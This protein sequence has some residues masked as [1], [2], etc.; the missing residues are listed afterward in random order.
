MQHTM[1]PTKPTDTVT[2]PKEEWLTTRTT[3]IEGVTK[4]LPAPKAPKVAGYTSTL[5][6]DDV[7]LRLKELQKA[8]PSAAI[9]MKEMVSGLLLAALDNSTT[10]TAGKSLAITIALEAHDKQREALIQ[11]QNQ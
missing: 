10:L 8:Q 4:T 2:I 11:L 5:V 3:T 9:G 6:R 7:F 1:N